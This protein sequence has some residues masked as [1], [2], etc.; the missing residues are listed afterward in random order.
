VS[1]HLVDSS[2][3][4]ALSI[5]EH[6]HHEVSRTWLEALEP[7]AT[8]LFCRPTQ[9]AF[10][11]LFTTSALMGL[12]GLKPV[13]NQ[14]AWAR[15]TGLLADPRIALKRDEP[16]GTEVTWRRFA[17][18]PSASPKLWMDAYLAAFAVAGGY[19]LVTTDRAFRQFPGLDVTVLD[20]TAV[21]P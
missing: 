3:W 6:V 7:S 8:L 5:Q 15:Y 10:L 13:T 12:Y 11:R 21:S 9:Q 2:V 17:S 16:E 20:S 4:V 14:A 18:R 1:E 19:R